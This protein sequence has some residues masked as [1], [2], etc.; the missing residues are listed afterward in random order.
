MVFPKL[1]QF[2]FMYLDA[3]LAFNFCGFFFRYVIENLWIFVPTG[4][5]VS[6]GVF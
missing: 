3:V 6:T 1:F 4:A 2:F 5:V